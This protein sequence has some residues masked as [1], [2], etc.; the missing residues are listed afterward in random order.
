MAG[1]WVVYIS[2]VLLIYSVAILCLL[3]ITY[4]DGDRNLWIGL[5]GGSIGY[6]L[7]SPRLKDS[8]PRHLYK[9]DES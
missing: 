2:Q 1:H 4:T 7:P 3:K 5:L 8:R 9:N 6:M